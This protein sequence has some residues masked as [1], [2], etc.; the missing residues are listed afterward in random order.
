MSSFFNFWLWFGVHDN[1]VDSK[2]RLYLYLVRHNDD[3]RLKVAEFNL[4]K[5]PDAAAPHDERYYFTVVFGHTRLIQ[6]AQ[7]RMWFGNENSIAWKKTMWHWSRIE[8]FCTFINIQAGD[9]L[10]VWV[11]VGS[12]GNQSITVRDFNLQLK[13]SDVSGPDDSSPQ[14]RFDFSSQLFEFKIF[15][16]FKIDRVGGWNFEFELFP[17]GSVGNSV[18]IEMQQVTGAASS[19][20]SSSAPA[21]SSSSEP[22]IPPPPFEYT[23]GSHGDDD[24]HL[25]AHMFSHPEHGVDD[26]DH[27]P[28][29]ASSGHQLPPF[30]PFLRRYLRLVSSMFLHWFWMSWDK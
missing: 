5:L 19:S 21:S 9:T 8:I 30:W 1:Q 13:Y 14:V 15:S 23:A 4:L 10:E 7:V 17:Q 12:G 26:A 18:A 3:G 11:V 22:D 2:S 27:E 16:E 29:E 6:A 20:A 28:G 24:D 25:H